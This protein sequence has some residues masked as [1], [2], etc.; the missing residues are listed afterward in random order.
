ME[1][2]NFHEM[3]L[4]DLE[5]LKQ[6]LLDSRNTEELSTDRGSI[7]QRILLVNKA[8]SDKQQQLNG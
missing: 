5:N 1:T 3:A 8:I 2:Y 4:G 6:F 7:N